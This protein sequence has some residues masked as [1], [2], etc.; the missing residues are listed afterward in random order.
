MAENPIGKGPIGQGPIGPK[1]PATAS[2]VTYAFPVDS[3]TLPKGRAILAAIIAVTSFAFAPT[4]VENQNNAGRWYAPLNEP[5]KKLSLPAT[6][7]QA[8]AFVKLEEDVS[9]RPKWYAPLNEPPKK[10]SLPVTQQQ[11]LAFVKLEEDVSSRPKWYAQLN[12]PPIK[13]YLLSSLQQTSAFTKLEEDVSSRPKWYAPLNEPPKKL[14]LPATQQQATIWTQLV[15]N[16]NLAQ[17]YQRLET[18]TL[19]KVPAAAGDVSWSTFTPAAAEVVTVDKWYAP[20]E[21][22]VR[23]ITTR[24]PY[25]PLATQF[26]ANTFDTWYDWLGEPIRWKG[27]RP[28]N[29]QSEIR[30]TLVDNTNLTQWYARLE[31]PPT[32]L[33]LP[34]SQQYQ[35]L[36]TQFVANSF[37]TE[38][39][40]LSEPTRWRGLEPAR[41]QSTIWAPLVFNAALHWHEALNEPIVRAKLFSV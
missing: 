41:Q 14:S 3:G 13:K 10:L 5:P 4:P 27:L 2:S 23:R 29:Q 28:A 33:S 37:D 18:P 1:P 11:P 12:E 34:A 22:P 31:T 39:A 35:P 20:L 15:D 32:K 38:Y 9:S 7:Q 25:Q 26:V 8:L 19:R 16:V 17:W 6:Q 30:E 21:Q 24:E 36:A 40:R